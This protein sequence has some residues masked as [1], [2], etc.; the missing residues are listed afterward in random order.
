MI[1]S[2]KE[3]LANLQRIR[4]ENLHTEVLQIPSDELVYNVDLNA[5]TIDTPAYLSTETDHTAETVFFLVDRYYETYDLAQSTCIIE[6]INAKNDFGIYLVPIYDLETYAEEGKMLIP[7]VIQG[8]VTAAAGPVKYAIR[9]YHLN[10]VE[11]PSGTEIG[12]EYVYD[13][14][15]N[16]QVA[17]SRILK[18]MGETFFD[19]AESAL[20][21]VTTTDGDP[22]LIDTWQQLY[23]ELVEILKEPSEDD[24]DHIKGALNLYWTVLD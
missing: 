22:V 2:A 19:N 15:I 8:K 12:T 17:Q 18:G 4:N 21:G 6:F 7:W 9:F 3:Y 20:D 11:R 10:K 14:I 16:T 24:P 5:R 1:T 13:Y 23:N